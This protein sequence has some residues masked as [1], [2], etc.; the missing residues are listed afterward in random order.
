MNLDS[1]VDELIK[2][3]AA[4]ALVRAPARGANLVHGTLRRLMSKSADINTAPNVDPAPIPYS[5]KLNPVDA[6]TRLPETASV[7]PA[8]VPGLLGTVEVPKRYIDDRKHNRAWE[9]ER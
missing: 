1:F 7:R 3:G 4:K 6:S 8:V 2:V 9:Y 5:I